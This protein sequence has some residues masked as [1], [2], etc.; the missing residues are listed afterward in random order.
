MLELIRL[1]SFG[2]EEFIGLMSLL[3]KLRQMLKYKGTEVC[4]LIKC[5]IETQFFKFSI[6]SLVKSSK[7]VKRNVCVRDASS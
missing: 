7:P 2:R 6:L 4:Q 5:G 1:E 3:K